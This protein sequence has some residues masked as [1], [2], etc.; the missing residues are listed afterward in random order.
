MLDDPAGGA[1][2]PGVNRQRMFGGEMQAERQ[3]RSGN[4]GRGCAA[5]FGT[6]DPAEAEQGVAVGIE[7]AEQ[8]GAETTRIEEFQQGSM[9]LLGGSGNGE[10]P[11][12]LG[13]CEESYLMRPPGSGRLRGVPAPQVLVPRFGKPE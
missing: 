12:A 8:P 13:T 6:V 4:L 10:K 3:A 5:R 11:F 7:C 9:V 1:G 2:G